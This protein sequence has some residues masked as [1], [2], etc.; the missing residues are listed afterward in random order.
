MMMGLDLAVA[1]D[2]KRSTMAFSDVVG[3]A[4]AAFMPMPTTAMYSS[5]E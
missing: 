1:R 3:D 5:D 4:L 2:A